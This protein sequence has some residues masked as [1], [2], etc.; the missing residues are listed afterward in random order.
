MSDLVIRVDPATAV[1][2]VVAA[3]TGDVD[4][5]SAPELVRRLSGLPGGGLVLDVSGVEFLDIGGLRALL[6]LDAGLRGAGDR[7]VLAAASGPVRLVLDH[8][9]LDQPLDAS[10]TVAQAIARNPPRSDTDR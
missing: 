6:A 3:V 1:R 4:R 10:P 5:V 8:V 7:L 9:E 2:P